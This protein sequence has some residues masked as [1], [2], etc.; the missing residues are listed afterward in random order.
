MNI[1]FFIQIAIFVCCLSGCSKT[2][3]EEQ[4]EPAT[5]REHII[6][7]YYKEHKTFDEEN[8]NT[9]KNTTGL[10]IKVSDYSI[11]RFYGSFD[12]S[13][14][15]FIE[16]NLG[17]YNYPGVVTEYLY[18]DNLV[19]TIP[20]YIPVVWKNHIFYGIY[21][22]IYGTPKKDYNGEIIGSWPLQTDSLSAYDE[23]LLTNQDIVIIQDYINH[24]QGNNTPYPD[25]PLDEQY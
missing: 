24:Y 11:K 8:F 5:V 7:D 2:N 22:K 4:F 1:N 23:G 20:S 10:K 15:A 21:S 25:T 12:G 14:V 17:L 18:K 16:N 3:V 6:Y 9:L 13:Y 19:L